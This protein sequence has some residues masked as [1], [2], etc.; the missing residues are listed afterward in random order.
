MLLVLNKYYLLHKCI[1]HDQPTK[2]LKGM[3]KS[4]KIP[5][6]LG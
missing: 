5:N 2:L 1:S 6:D 3:Q 4:N